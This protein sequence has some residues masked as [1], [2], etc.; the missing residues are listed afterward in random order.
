MMLQDHAAYLGVW[1]AWLTMG[2]ALHVMRPATAPR[3]PEMPTGIITKANGAAEDQH[4]P[5]QPG[6]GTQPSH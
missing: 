2:M 5:Q 4:C 6:A 1:Q 3:A